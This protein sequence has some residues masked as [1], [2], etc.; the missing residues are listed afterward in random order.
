VRWPKRKPT[1]ATVRAA[2]SFQ[3]CS[4]VPGTRKGVVQASYP[5]CGLAA[6]A[7]AAAALAAVLNMNSQSGVW[8]YCS[9]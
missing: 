8:H 2:P 4:C 6:A 9:C 3:V 5:G 7:A 1:S